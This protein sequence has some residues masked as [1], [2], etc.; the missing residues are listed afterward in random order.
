MK[1]SYIICLL[2]LSLAFRGWANNV[3]IEGE[4][5]VDPKDVNAGTN[6]AT[7]HFKVKWD[8]SWRDEFNYDAVYFFLKYKVEGDQEKWHHAYL[9]DNGCVSKTSGYEVLMSKSGTAANMNEGLFLYRSA[10]DSGNAEVDIELKWKIDMN[11]DRPLEASM[12]TEGMVFVSAMGIE[13]VY[14]PRGGFRAG[15]TKSDSTFYNKCMTI[16]PQYD[17]LSDTISAYEYVSYCQGTAEDI[18]A[19]KNPPYFAVNRVNDI[20]Q[21]NSNA[22]VGCMRMADEGEVKDYWM[23]TFDKPKKIKNIAIE[24]VDGHYA[25]DWEF[26]GKNNGQ[27]TNLK[28]G[29]SMG[30][31]WAVH[32]DRTYPPTAA[33]VVRDTHMAYSQY[34]IAIKA[35][36]N[37]SMPIIK[38]IAMSEVDMHDVIDNSVLIYEPVTRMSERRGLYAKDGD[39]WSGVTP[40]WY[41]NGYPAFF[42]MKYEVSQEQYVAF[43]NKLTANQQKARTIGSDLNRLK[44]GDYVFGAKERPSARNGIKLAAISVND[45][46]FVFTNDLNPD[47]REYG[48]EDDGQ[49]LAC[50]Y[51][52]AGDMLAYADWAGLRPLTELEYEKMARRPF[53]QESLWGEYA[54]NSNKNYVEAKA[55]ETGTAGTTKEKLT[56]GNIN[57]GKYLPGPVRCGAFAIAGQDQNGSGSSFWGVMELSGNVDEVYYN[58]N[59]AGRQFHGNLDSYHGNGI[60]GEVG[61]SDIAENIWPVDQNAFCLKGGHFNGNAKIAAISDRSRHWGI[62]QNLSSVFEYRDSTVGFRLGRTAPVRSVKSELTLENGL[63]TASAVAY[64]S[65]C[66]GTV[67]TLRGSVPAEIRGAYRVA[68]F[69]SGDNGATWDLIEGEERPSLTITDLRNE[70]TQEDRFLE[71]WYKRYIYSASGDAVVSN[72]AKLKVINQTI[73]INRLTDTVDVYNRSKGIHI[74]MEQSADIKWYFYRPYAENKEIYPEYTIRPNKEYL[75]YFKYSDFTDVSTVYDGDQK[76]L[77]TVNMLNHCR[78]V[79]TINVYVHKRPD[80]QNNV[81]PDDNLSL[82]RAFRCGDYLRDNEPQGGNVIY[83]TVEI[84]GRCWMAENLKRVPTTGNHLCYANNAANCEAYGRLYNW[85]AATYGDV[86]EG[87]QGVCPKGWHLPTNDE[88]ISMVQAGGLNITNEVYTADINN[89]PTENGAHISGKFF[90]SSLSYGV[91]YDANGV[92]TNT[93]GFSGVPAGGYFY[94]Y[95][96]S[97]PTN[98]NIN[99]RAT[100]YYDIGERGWWWTSTTTGTKAAYWYASSWTLQYMPYYVRMDKDGEMWFNMDINAASTST[101]AYLL[102]TIFHSKSHYY[103]LYSGNNANGALN[104]IRANFYFSVRCI[105]NAD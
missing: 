10:T 7:L 30:D 21:D 19:S 37:N 29:T 49:T 68:W 69:L 64:D 74:S 102:N 13:M 22:W 52:N 54:W 97:Y 27:W 71:Y 83:R 88:W 26:Q 50:N 32:S 3:R 92:G 9:M 4:V 36:I 70:N 75:N 53:P 100:N 58:A 86:T 103:I 6:E 60:I 12:F 1:Y 39:S 48:Q 79:D 72:P 99:S 62:Y 93:N 95:S 84:G 80:V 23:V 82:N 2:F 96:G 40:E 105:R 38:T 44:A 89:N 51:L 78:F 11:P 41:P 47:D 76:V 14:V 15:D 24:S 20:S 33:I 17:I 87:T 59:T 67:Y 25:T 73:L 5:R 104:Y 66:S 16:P 90:K 63:T 31:Q 42:T 94:T 77:I 65:V 45:A 98:A 57:A 43:L 101:P 28:A 81:L 18:A 85:T 34:R 56:G 61:R 91:A 35:T 46:P 8:N 55:F